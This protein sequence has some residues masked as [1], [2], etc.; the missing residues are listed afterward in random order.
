RATVL[1]A[2]EGADHITSHEDQACEGLWR[3]I[4]ERYSPVPNS[5]DDE[6]LKLV[7]TTPP[8]TLGFCLD[9]VLRVCSR[10]GRRCEFVA[11]ALAA[12][13][14][15][16]IPN[17]AAV[18]PEILRELDENLVET[19]ARIEVFSLHEGLQE[20][21]QNQGQTQLAEELKQQFDPSGI[22]PSGLLPA[23]GR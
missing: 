16:V 1:A 13:A 10:R 19:P 17:G 3:R 22:L 8:D 15:I 7:L 2:V 14:D 23:I 11:D 6:N 21:L 18:A 20:F 12:R 9:H 4:A 5:A